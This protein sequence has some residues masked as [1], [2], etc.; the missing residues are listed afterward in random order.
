MALSWNEGWIEPTKRGAGGH[1]GLVRG[2]RRSGSSAGRWSGGALGALVG[3]RSDETLQTSVGAS[4][5]K[6]QSFH[7]R[8]LHGYGRCTYSET[9]EEDLCNEFVGRH[10]LEVL[11][12]GPQN[13]SKIGLDIIVGSCVS[14][15]LI[16]VDSE[17]MEGIMPRDLRCGSVHVGDGLDDAEVAFVA[18]SRRG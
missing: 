3:L 14:L 8:L 9:A 17:L 7:G 1:L 5:A 6:C 13:S 15:A 10:R 2:C 4:T 11:V 18:R 12:V 16:V